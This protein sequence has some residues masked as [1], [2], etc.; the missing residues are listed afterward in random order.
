MLGVQI[1]GYGKPFRIGSCPTPTPAR[2]DVCVAVKASGLCGTDLHLRDGRQ[3]LGS[4]P[5]IPGHE[6]AGEIIEIGEGVTGWS[7]GQRVLV[8]IDVT[9]GRCVDCLAGQTQRCRLLHRL[10][11]ERDGGHA[12]VEVVPAQNLILLP[13][14][15]RYEDACILP[16]ATGC[17]Y[18]SLV[19]QGAIGPNQHVLILGAGGLGIHGIQIARLAGAEVIAT[20]RRE[21]RLREAS[22][23]GALAINPEKQDLSEVVRAQTA[24]EGLDIVADCVGTVES[25]AAGLG[26][27]RPGGKLLVIAYQDREFHV[28][29]LPLFS[30]EKQIIGCRGTNKRELRD[31]L[32]LVSRGRL[33]SVI[34]ATFPLRDFDKAVE[35]L[36]KGAVTGRTVVTR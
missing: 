3:D 2:G 14:D 29:S 9:C 21:H 26:L 19:T 27:L 25:V 20:S 12:E 30:R 1:V 33:T 23:Y 4:L 28:P 35:A 8:T 16:D 22:R 6:S 32:D 36:E 18:H 24:G 15:T 17:M 11:F 13:A 5:R 34:G 10:G 31:V 7:L